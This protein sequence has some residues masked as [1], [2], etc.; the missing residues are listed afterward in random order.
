MCI[1]AQ[2]AVRIFD[3]A[4]CDSRHQCNSTENQSI[5]FS[6]KILKRVEQ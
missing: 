4:T 2:V 5:K 6:A 1:R 3:L